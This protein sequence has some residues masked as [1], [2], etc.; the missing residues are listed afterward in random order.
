MTLDIAP[1]HR[2]SLSWPQTVSDALRGAAGVVLTAAAFLVAL[3]GVLLWLVLS[4]A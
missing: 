3:N 1:S 4:G 2:I